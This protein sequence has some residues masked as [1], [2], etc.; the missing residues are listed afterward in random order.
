MRR[1]LALLV[2]GSALAA[3][4]AAAA[5]H[6]T[7]PGARTV[8]ADARARVFSVPG[9]GRTA[10]RYFGCLTGHRPYLLAVD[11][12]PRSSTGTRTQTSLFRLAGAWVAWHVAS[13]SEARAGKPTESVQARSLA[14]ARRRLSVDVSG[15]PLTTLEVLADGTVGW[16]LAIGDYR[17]IDAVAHA[18]TTPTPIAYTR[19]IDSKTVRFAPDRVTWTQTGVAHSAALS[20]PAPLP[21]GTALGPQALDGRFGDCGTL[22]PVTPPAGPFTEATQLARA[23]DGDIVAAGTAGSGQGAAPTQDTF[24]IGRF[25]PAGA[26]DQSFG[27]HGVVTAVVPLPGGAQDADLTDAVV[28]PDGRILVAG[29]VRSSTP[30]HASVVLYRLNPDGSPDPSFGAGGFVQSAV[31]AATSAD[32][33]AIALTADGSILVAGQR[34]ARFYVA[35][36]KP[37]GTLDPTFGTDGLAVD[38]GKDVSAAQ[39]L[40]VEPDGTFFAGGQTASE[41]MLV[42]FAADGVAQSGDYHAP[43]A[44]SGITALA[45]LPGGG[46]VAAGAATNVLAKGQLFLAR[47]TASGVPDAAFGAGGF[48]L[49]RQVTQPRSIA[50]APDGHLLVTASFLLRPGDYAGSGLVQYAA[51]GAR[52]TSFGLRGALGGVSSLGLTNNDVLLDPASGTAFVAQGNGQHFGISRFALGAPA[53]GAVAGEPSVCA[54]ATGTSIAPLRT[55]RKLGVSLRLRAPGRVRVDAT[56]TVGGRTAAVGHV[57]VLRPFIEGGVATI[58]VAPAAVK[59]LRGARQARLTL[60]AGAPGGAPRS[61]VATLTG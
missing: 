59:L 49:D 61:Y 28:E 18:T 12:T 52:D 11:V 36:L 58:P 60:T 35:R 25:T 41:P 1:L 51:G 32:A 33:H 7:L 4:P 46:V 48:V 50:V 43:P 44:A 23:P 22:V 53:T 55:L 29:V 17:E 38:P 56:I 37:D 20:A 5:Q 30:G 54:M 21:G 45:A 27:D 40:A 24:V 10:R 15:E 57:T 3:A 47:Y 6:C 14:G 8:V 42:R 31:P 26:F 19:G 9:S 13:S 16:V 39:A 34:D 2:A